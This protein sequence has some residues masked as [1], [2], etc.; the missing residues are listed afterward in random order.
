MAE[1][2]YEALR[3]DIREIK[4]RERKES[5]AQDIYEQY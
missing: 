1:I 5:M 2:F 4:M 3:G